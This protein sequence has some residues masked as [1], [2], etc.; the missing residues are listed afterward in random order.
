MDSED[1]MDGMPV[2]KVFENNFINE[3]KNNFLF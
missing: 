1:Y 3:I 2:D